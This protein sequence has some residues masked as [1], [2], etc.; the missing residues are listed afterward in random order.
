M[1]APTEARYGKVEPSAS[2]KSLRAIAPITP[3]RVLGHPP[4][5]TSQLVTPLVSKK[6]KA[7]AEGKNQEIASSAAA[8]FGV[9]SQSSWRGTCLEET[10]GPAGGVWDCRSVGHDAGVVGSRGNFLPLSYPADGAARTGPDTVPGDLRAS[11]V[12][13]D[14]PS[15]LGSGGEWNASAEVAEWK[16][17]S[18]EEV[19]LGSC[20]RRSNSSGKV[21]LRWNECSRNV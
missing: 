21:S 14:G 11:S 6:S 17:G 20:C 16:R 8:A 18:L 1:S 7:T 13:G 4:R 2:E 19:L 15:M 10:S 3:G 12:T 9:S 5:P